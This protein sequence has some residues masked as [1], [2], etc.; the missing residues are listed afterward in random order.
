MSIEITDHF[1]S[2]IEEASRQSAKN[3]LATMSPIFEK[4]KLFDTDDKKSGKYITSSSLS[5]LKDA[6]NYFGQA[7]NA[8]LKNDV[9]LSKHFSYYSELRSSLSLMASEGIAI[10]DGEHYYIDSNEHVRQFTRESGSLNKLGTH[11]MIWTSLE[12]WSML[13][14]SRE[15]LER[16][17]HIESKSLKEWIEVCDFSKWAGLSHEIYKV[18]GI[19]LK[20]LAE[21]RQM[22]NIVSYS[23]TDIYIQTCPVNENLK[24][25]MKMWDLLEPNFKNVDF[26]ILVKSLSLID[27]KDPSTLI[28]YLIE[29]DTLKESLIESIAQIDN[30]VLDTASIVHSNIS[31]ALSDPYNHLQILGRAFL[32]LRIATGSVKLLYKDANIE[33]SEISFW[34]NQI[35]KEYGLTK[36]SY[37]LESYAD[38]WTDV[39]DNAIQQIYTY[40]IS[41]DFFTIKQKLSYPLLLLTETQ[42]PLLW[43]IEY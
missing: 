35:T 38:M 20:F 2:Q 15:L 3:I 23:P 26:C 11:Q 24:F 21:D 25:V 13:P 29:N 32:L 42:R 5:H 30:T 27:C 31:D 41:E 1:K 43:G 28:N 39:E 37:E 17:V 18:I 9:A 4:N 12:A 33:F 36:N 22:R 8:V 34:T 40:D 16:I 14:K 19:D 6:W 7:I 10:Y